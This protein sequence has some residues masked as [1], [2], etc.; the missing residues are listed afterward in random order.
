MKIKFI[1]W[2]IYKNDRGERFVVE[3]YNDW[4][5]SLDNGDLYRIV[6]K[7]EDGEIMEIE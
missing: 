7:S 1:G 6:E 5:M 4:V 3:Y 2:G